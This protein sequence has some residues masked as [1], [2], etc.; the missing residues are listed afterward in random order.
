[1]NIRAK[2]GFI[3][4]CAFILSLTSCAHHFTLSSPAQ[5]TQLPVSRGFY[6]GSFVYD[7]PWQYRGSHYGT[8]EFYY[9]Y[10]TDNLL[11][12]RAVTIPRPFAILHFRE[13]A[14]GSEPQWVTLQPDSKAFHFFPYHS[15]HQ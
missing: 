8:Q 15:R 12:R 4:P 11:H 9:Y 7:S 2:L 14:F 13:V 1:M 3:L 5:V 6:G 10:H